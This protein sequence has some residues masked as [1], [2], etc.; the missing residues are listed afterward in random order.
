MP[1]DPLHINL[2]G[3]GND[4]CDCLERHF[5]SEILE[6]YAENHLKKSGQGPGGKFNGPSI[7][8]NL[9]EDVLII[10]ENKLP[11]SASSFI[12][13]FRAIRNLHELCVSEELGD[14][15][16]VLHDFKVNF[17]FLN[18]EFLLPMTLKIHVILHHYSDYFEWTG[19]TMRYTNA[20]FTETAHATFKMS[21]RIHKFKVTRKIGTPI[22]KELALKS[23]VWH[24]SRRVGYVSPSDFVLRRKSSPRIGSPGSPYIKKSKSIM[25]PLVE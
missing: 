5:S 18:E 23:L 11:V 7:K 1:P 15:Y 14:F 3:A 4:V 2:L 17:E 24:N 19:N 8:Y 6:F 22:H 20:E 10:L 13:Y 25:S 16:N 12:N 9:R 21:E